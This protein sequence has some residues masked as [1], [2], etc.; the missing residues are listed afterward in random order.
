MNFWGCVTA[1]VCCAA[2]LTWYRLSL[3]A[4]PGQLCETHTWKSS[5]CV[6]F[7][8]L[9]FKEEITVSLLRSRIFFWSSVKMEK[10]KKHPPL[11]SVWKAQSVHVPQL[12]PSGTEAL[13]G[14]LGGWVGAAWSLGV[15]QQCSLQAVLA[16]SCNSQPARGNLGLPGLRFMDCGMTKPRTIYWVDQCIGGVLM[17]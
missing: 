8:C 17:V 1:A 11:S 2:A 6:L 4:G 15:T 12:H 13:L 16:S 10:K 5:V 9:A 7:W 3:A 14:R